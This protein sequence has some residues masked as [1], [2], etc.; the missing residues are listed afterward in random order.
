MRIT[1]LG[2]SGFLGTNLA[3][4]VLANTDWHVRAAARDADKLHQIGQPSERLQLQAADALDYDSVVS[5]LSDTDVAYYFI[6]LM[7][8]KERDFY[9]AELD[10]ARIFARAATVAGVRRIVYVGGLGTDEKS[11]SRHLRGRYETGTILRTEFSDVIELRASIIIGEGSVGYDIIRNVANKFPIMVMPKAAD[12]P[13]QPIALRDAI[14]YLIA[15]ATVP[16][17]KSII[18]DIGG[19]KILSYADIYR[20]YAK[21]IGKHRVVVPV[22]FIPAAFSAKFLDL[23]TPEIH[24]RIGKIMFESMAF[25]MV[26]QND[27]AKSLFPKIIPSPI[28]TSF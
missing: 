3:R 11:T 28:E 5:V 2:A 9:Q 7:G 4:T 12:T 23:V 8:H 10:A 6:H 16:T 20:M 21:H 18:V 22:P 27:N 19:P 17:S 13:I 1:I 15:S 24:A 26:V 14:D 25:E